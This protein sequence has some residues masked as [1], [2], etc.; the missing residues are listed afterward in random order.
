MH[1]MHSFLQHMQADLFVL[2]QVCSP[3]DAGKYL[4]SKLGTCHNHIIQ[5]TFCVCL[6]CGT[7]SAVIAL[8]QG[9]ICTTATAA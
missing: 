6:L 7:Q 3:A 4:H 9:I 2:F 1:P 5:R 8:S